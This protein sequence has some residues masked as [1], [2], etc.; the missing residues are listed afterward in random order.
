MFTVIFV[1]DFVPAAIGHGGNHRT[2][3]TLHE[4]ESIVGKENLIPFIYPQWYESSYG[5]ARPSL[6]NRIIR[7]LGAYAENPF[8][9]LAYNSY[10]AR[11]Y[12][13]R[14]LRCYQ[15]VV[16]QVPKPALCIVEHSTFADLMRINVQH[17]LPT[18]GCFHNVE[19]LDRKGWGL[20]LR[21]KLAAYAAAVDFLHE[22]EV[23]TQCTERLFISKIEVGL[24]SGLGLPARYYPYLPVGAIRQRLLRIRQER[25][26]TRRVPGLFLLLGNATHSTT[27]ESFA[28]FIANAK[29]NPLPRGIRVLVVGKETDK[30]LP[31]GTVV[32]GLELK[33]WVEQEELDRL[34]VCAQAVLAPQRLGFGAL[35]RVPETVCAGIPVLLSRRAAYATDVPPGTWVIDDDWSAWAKTM[36][37]LADADSPG[38]AAL[39]QYVA[40]EQA[41]PRTLTQ[42]IAGEL[43]RTR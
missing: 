11:H 42:V 12:D 27:K 41:Q 31:P 22:L 28:W 2:F 32:R 5:N 24:I 14:L 9:V 39:E 38:K 36:E 1:S 15:D 29:S 3:Q 7:R 21:G 4:L 18:V 37:E 33:G 25:T 13:H 43:P 8:K 30:L 20:G 16:R 26:N 10:A 17:R 19:A 34:L 35:T 23:L 40:W 6:A